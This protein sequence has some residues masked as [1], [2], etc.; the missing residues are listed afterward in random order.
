M[1]SLKSAAIDAGFKQPRIG[2]WQK[3]NPVPL[4]SKLNYLSNS[5]EYFSS[6]VKGANPTFNSKYDIGVY[7]YPIVH[8]K[9]RLGHPTQKPIE[10]IKKM[11]LKHSNS[12]D[13]ILDTF[14][15][16]ATIAAASILTNRKFISIESDEKYYNIGKNRI[17]KLSSNRLFSLQNVEYI[18]LL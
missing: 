4:N 14:S 17:E 2:H 1:E 6:F 10:M 3:T 12:D 8:G 7:E 13:I 5:R 18:N 9:E 16:T 15:G 11:I